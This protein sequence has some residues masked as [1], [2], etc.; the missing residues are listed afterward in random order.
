MA[1]RVVP[2]MSPYALAAGQTVVARVKEFGKLPAEITTDYR[3][4]HDAHDAFAA[5]AP[6]D[7]GARAL[8]PFVDRAITLPAHVCALL[9]DAYQNAPVALNAAQTERVDAAR[10]IRAVYP[11]DLRDVTNVVFIEEW[12]VV[13]TILGRLT[14]DAPVAKAVQ[15]LGL[16]PDVTFARSLHA[17]YGQALGLSAEGPPSASATALGTWNDRF[18]DLLVAAT[19]WSR[20]MPGL[21]ALFVDPYT[22]QL[23]AQREATRRERHKQATKAA[24]SETSPK[25]SPASTT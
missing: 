8:D 1:I 6:A 13:H 20:K 23:A 5:A 19:Y 7:P 14:D 4:W 17:L 3:S 2:L 15:R 12:G 16:A 18:K 10:T 25:G 9:L 24:A 21:T 11:A 22:Q